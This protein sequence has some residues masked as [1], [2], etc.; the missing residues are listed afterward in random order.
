MMKGPEDPKEDKR[1]NVHLQEG[2]RSNV[3]RSED[4]VAH[5]V[6]NNSR[7]I[8]VSVEND[9]FINLYNNIQFKILQTKVAILTKQTDV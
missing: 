8:I 5:S 1:H 3:T 7:I 6:K 9:K 2:K 4:Q